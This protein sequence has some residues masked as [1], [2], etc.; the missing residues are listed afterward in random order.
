MIV[1]K[2]NASIQNLICGYEKILSACF[3]SPIDTLFFFKICVA[4]ISWKFFFFAKA[5]SNFSERTS[6]LLL[7]SLHHLEM[8]SPMTC[9]D[10]YGHLLPLSKTRCL[11]TETT[12]S[13][14]SSSRDGKSEDT[15]RPIWSSAPFVEDSM[16]ID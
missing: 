7:V 16:S 3:P 14:F 6:R 11:S 15:Q 8:A 2:Q 4:L 10:Q 9:R 13:L 12:F 5:C 1:Q